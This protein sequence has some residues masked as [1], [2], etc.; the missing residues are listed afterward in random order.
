MPPKVRKSSSEDPE[1]KLA[2][3]VMELNFHPFAMAQVRSIL[4]KNTCVSVE[5]V[6]SQ[7]A[8]NGF[9]KAQLI[10]MI[11]AVMQSK[12]Q[13][14]TPSVTPIVREL[15]S[16]FLQFLERGIASP[17][18]V[19]VMLEKILLPENADN[20]TTALVAILMQLRHYLE[21]WK[22]VECIKMRL[23]EAIARE[24]DV[25]A[26]CKMIF[27]VDEIE[28]Q[29][30]SI[31][32]DKERCPHERLNAIKE[33]ETAFH[34]QHRQ[35]HALTRFQH[36]IAC[37]IPAPSE[38]DLLLEQIRTHGITN[39][40][41]PFCGRALVLAILGMF[42]DLPMHGCDTH[43]SDD[44][45]VQFAVKD[46]APQFVAKLL[47]ES[48]QD[49]KIMEILSWPPSDLHLKEDPQAKC[50]PMSPQAQ[51]LRIADHRLRLVVMVS[52]LPNP[53]INPC[54]PSSTVIGSTDGEVVLSD[55]TRYTLLA[56]VPVAHTESKEYSL[57]TPVCV[58]LRI[59]QSDHP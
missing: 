38:M 5:Q 43:L 28:K 37:W 52:D 53:L 33:L 44:T 7:E 25:K 15:F 56:K 55:V 45:F 4:L 30:E 35:S 20:D 13:Q 2:R 14:D 23:P 6:A 54:D 51:L 39:V 59:F 26:W 21:E 8:I 29:I 17:T 3:Q 42:I 49:A 40:V 36:K 41:D 47:A 34:E 31:L 57:C 58:F 27:A 16:I 19:Q 46:D 22:R 24:A 11:M 50:H 32:Q 48:P 9:K 10:D 1:L 12:C 18:K